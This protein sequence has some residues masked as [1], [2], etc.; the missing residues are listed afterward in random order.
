MNYLHYIYTVVTATSD[1]NVTKA[2]F[3]AAN[4]LRISWATTPPEV[5]I[6]RRKTSNIT[7]DNRAAEVLDEPVYQQETW[8]QLR[9]VDAGAD[10][11]C[12]E[13]IAVRHEDEDRSP[14]S[15]MVNKTNTVL[16]M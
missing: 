10:Q 5:L 4:A 16:L 11:L 15:I 7:A 1:C 9:I 6:P 13:M 14:S 3:K 2:E 8:C 12:D